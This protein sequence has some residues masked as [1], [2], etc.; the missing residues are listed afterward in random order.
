MEK[1]LG[2]IEA[3]HVAMRKLQLSAAGLSASDC[4]PFRITMPQAREGRQTGAGFSSR[5]QADVRFTAHTWILYS[6]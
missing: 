2:R 3:G 5:F 4:Y 1:D 6:T